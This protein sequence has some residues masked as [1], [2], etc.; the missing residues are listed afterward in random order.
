MIETRQIAGLVR[1]G[2][3]RSRGTNA[4]Q[5]GKRRMEKERRRDLSVNCTEFRNCH[6]GGGRE[7]IYSSPSVIYI[8]AT[9]LCLVYICTAL[10]FALFHPVK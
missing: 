4:M 5:K 2:A 8:A 10:Y 7:L 1:I 3:C 6:V 9:Y